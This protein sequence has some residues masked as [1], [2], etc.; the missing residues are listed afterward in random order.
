M[1]VCS[2]IK[3]ARTSRGNN[4]VPFYALAQNVARRAS[5]LIARQAA[6]R[7]VPTHADCRV[8]S[9]SFALFNS[10]FDPGIRNPSLFENLP[11]PENQLAGNQIPLSLSTLSVEK[12]RAQG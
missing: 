5:N 9:A 8:S 12:T 10:L 6:A 7:R 1:Y 11:I 4:N 2:E 3:I